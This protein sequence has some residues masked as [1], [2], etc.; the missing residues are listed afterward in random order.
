MHT[1][2]GK[3][4]ASSYSRRLSCFYHISPLKRKNISGQEPPPYNSGEAAK[5]LEGFQIVFATN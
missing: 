3:G 5:R 4:A 2:K 1:C